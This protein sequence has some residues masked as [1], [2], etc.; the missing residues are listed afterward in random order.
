MK[1]PVAAIIAAKLLA[2]PDAQVRKSALLALAEMPGI[3]TGRRGDLMQRWPTSAMSN[4][5]WLN[6]AA[7]IAACRHD[8]G[9]LKAMFAAH[10]GQGRPDAV[11]GRRQAGKPDSQSLV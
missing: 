8:A 1:R 6:D 9:F 7:A 10:P 2:D 5:R 11:R 4:D 3:G